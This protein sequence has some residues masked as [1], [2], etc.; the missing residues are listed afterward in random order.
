MMMHRWKAFVAL[1]GATSAK[2]K[3][4]GDARSC[5]FLKKESLCEKFPENSRILLNGHFQI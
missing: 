3:R 2:T 4:K 5:P 1:V